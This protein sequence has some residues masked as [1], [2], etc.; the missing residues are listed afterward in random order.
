MTLRRQKIRKPRSNAAIYFHSDAFD[1]HNNK[2][3]GRRIAGESFLRGFIKHA[4]IDDLCGSVDTK[5]QGEAFV[6]FAKQN[7]Y[8]DE[9]KTRLI[10]NSGLVGN[11]TILHLPGPSLAAQA[12]RR[13]QIG[14]AA[15]SISGVTHTTAT[16]RIMQSMYDLRTAP[17]E[18]WDGIICTSNAVKA[19]VDY[20]LTEADRF[21]KDRFG[22]VPPRPQTPMIPLGLNSVDFAHDDAARK[23]WRDRLK[24]AP[25]DL[26][27]MTMS[28]LN[29]F[30]KFDPLP[31]FLA[32]ELAVAKTKHKIHFLAVGP[33]SDAITT[34]VF[35]DGAA[36]LAPSVTY[37]HVDGTIE[38]MA[39]GLWSAADIFT[40][41]VDNIQETFGLAPV[42]AMAAGLPVVVSDWDGFKDTISRETG[43]RI[44]TL[45]PK[46]G[47]M[48]REALAYFL[49]H[50][51]Y[52]Q[53]M[54]QNSFQTAIDVRR[55]AKAFVDLFN[56]AELRKS[57]GAAGMRRARNIYDWSRIIPM[58]QEFWAELDAIREKSVGDAKYMG[59]RTNPTALDPSKLFQRY[60]TE[61]A[62]FANRKFK[63]NV[64]TDAKSAIQDMLEL[65]EVPT[66][67]RMSVSIKHLTT[68][69]DFLQTD[70]FA[71]Y[72]MVHKGTGQM[73][74]PV[75]D[76]CLLWLLKYDFVSIELD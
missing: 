48:G 26:V 8:T 9:I 44:R 57:M 17:V 58:Y 67:K 56:S 45:G 16:K 2:L 34:R 12:W 4:R 30:G 18:Q 21:L 52:A 14:G 38:P 42:E 22:S 68:V 15:Y 75:L 40:H 35:E 53:Y 69:L 41:P 72:D 63:V 20:Q 46:P 11:Q 47:S 60:P 73:A 76:R 59:A 71:S 19:S 3:N 1:P 39:M 50:D 70:G 64:T 5:A 28:R 27:V 65:R 32:L 37:H 43:M 6:A 49:D 29:S 51:T 36:R 23:S 31:L 7:Q 13:R 54:A 24:I 74:K 55:L 66:L 33:Y 25:D 10:A 61:T 62:D